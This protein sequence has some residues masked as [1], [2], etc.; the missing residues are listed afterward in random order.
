MIAEALFN[1]YNQEY[2]KWRLALGKAG[3]ILLATPTIE[4]YNIETLVG[5]TDSNSEGGEGF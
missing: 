2:D 3:T 5:Y 4:K 1:Q